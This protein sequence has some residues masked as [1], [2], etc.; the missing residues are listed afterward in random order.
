MPLPRN[1]RLGLT[2]PDGELH[3]VPANVRAG[4]FVCDIEQG[5]GECE[6]STGV[7]EEVTARCIA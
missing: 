7:E 2:H 3:S 4:R 5:G 6:G 1:Y